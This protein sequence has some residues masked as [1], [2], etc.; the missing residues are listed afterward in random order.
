VCSCLRT[1]SLYTAASNLGLPEGGTFKS[2][3]TIKGFVRSRHLSGD[4]WAAYFLQL[5]AR[6]GDAHGYFALRLAARRHGQ[7]LFNGG[8][9]I[10]VICRTGEIELWVG[11]T[12]SQ[13]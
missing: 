11:P 6:A 13:L 10:I 1:L 7:L 9:K 8:A 2:E 3:P 4:R 5:P 12:K